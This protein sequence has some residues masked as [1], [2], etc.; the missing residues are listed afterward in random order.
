MFELPSFSRL[1]DTVRAT[2]PKFAVPARV[3]RPPTLTIKP[4][5]EQK[6]LIREMAKQV[7]PELL[8]KAIHLLKT[9]CGRFASTYS[10]A[11][12]PPMPW[13]GAFHVY[14]GNDP[15]TGREHVS[16]YN[17]DD[18]LCR[19]SH[20]ELFAYSIKHAPG[21]IKQVVYS[22]HSEGGANY[23]PHKGD[24]PML[25]EHLEEYRELRAAAPSMNA[26]TKMDAMEMIEQD[27]T[28]VKFFVSD[29]DS[30]GRN[31]LHP[32]CGDGLGA[33][34]YA[35]A[36]EVEHIDPNLAEDV[37]PVFSRSPYKLT[38]D[39]DRGYEI[40]YSDMSFGDEWGMATNQVL[41]N[42]NKELA[43]TSD[44]RWITLLK[45]SLF[46]QYPGL[47]G[48]LFAKARPHNEE[49]IWEALSED[50]GGTKYSGVQREL[51]KAIDEANQRRNE[52]MVMCNMSGK[53]KSHALRGW[54]LSEVSRRSVP[55]ATHRHVRKYKAPSRGQ[56]FIDAWSAGRAVSHREKY[57]ALCLDTKF[58][59]SE[60]KPHA[61]LPPEMVRVGLASTQDPM[62]GG[63]EFSLRS[64]A[65]T[66]AFHKMEVYQAF[67]G[68]AARV[69]PLRGAVT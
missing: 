46:D 54:Q 21:A 53:L 3:Y 36:A 48:A 15:E 35:T 20:L 6:L 16:L 34:M 1:P 12:P 11:T 56:R 19:G 25:K 63:P 61:L 40:I 41:V 62:V 23:V 37:P 57:T 8:R 31:A 24:L 2:L 43:R 44:D 68:W 64:W 27:S 32:G 17:H 7:D 5:P 52:A 55:R 10:D 29:A 47:T 49:I 51:L 30:L 26:L 50:E 45:L 4:D 28:M 69:K 39:F 9:E 65:R 59:F 13:R 18:F 60:D 42:I 22:A 14:W 58:N 33:S 66:A 38:P 67:G